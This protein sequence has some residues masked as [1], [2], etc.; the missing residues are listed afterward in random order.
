MSESVSFWTGSP[1]LNSAFS[2]PFLF[3]AVML[4]LIFFET[5]SPP[6]SCR[7]HNLDWTW[8]T[9]QTWNTNTLEFFESSLSPAIVPATPPI[10]LTHLPRSRA[11]PTPPRS[12][13]AGWGGVWVYYTTQQTKTNKSNIKLL[14]P[15]MGGGGGREGGGG[16]K[17]RGS[18][19]SY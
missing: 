17:N 16:I 7:H 1:P 15:T 19:T 9:R 12:P 5:I 11:P 6:A 14:Q 2:K 4:S 8:R 13:P 10:P 18:S 3:L